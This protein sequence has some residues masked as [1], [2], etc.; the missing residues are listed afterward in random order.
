MICLRIVFILLFVL[1][2]VSFAQQNTRIYLEKMGDTLVYFI[3]NNEPFPC[4]IEFSGN[5]VLENAKLEGEFIKMKLFDANSTRVPVAKFLQVD[6]KKKWGVKSM[7]NYTAYFGDVTITKY[8]E[9]YIYDLPFRSGSEFL[10]GQGYNGKF[11]HRNEYAIDF[12]MPIGTEILASR[13]GVVVKTVDHNTKNCVQ[14]A[15]K[16]LGNYVRIYHNDGTIADYYHL[17]YKGVKVEVGD[18]VQKGDVIAY[19]G[20]TG[21]SNGPHLHFVVFI[22]TKGDNGRKTI[23][24]LFRTGDGKKQEYLSEMKRYSRKY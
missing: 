2:E 3:D 10:V 21:Y 8:D 9:N 19:S 7:P 15:C 23:K 17:N 12:N 6:K 16:L 22:P 14:E 20:N 11:S 1:S 13:E 24:T 18:K 5:P 4:T